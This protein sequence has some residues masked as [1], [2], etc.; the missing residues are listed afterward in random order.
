MV[1][2]HAL[3]TQ[4]CAEE[5]RNSLGLAAGIWDLSA[6]MR[7]TLSED[8]LGGES[9]K[10]RPVLAC[11]AQTACD[12]HA[13][14]FGG[15]DTLHNPVG[16]RV[17]GKLLLSKERLQMC[18]FMGREWVALDQ[19]EKA[20]VALSESQKCMK[21]AL[22]QSSTLSDQS[23]PERG[24]DPGAEREQILVLTH[25]LLLLRTQVL[26][27]LGQH[28]LALQM[29]ADCVALL[30]D[31]IQEHSMQLAAVM[32]AE[33]GAALA[34]LVQTTLQPSDVAGA[35][36]TLSNRPEHA[37]G[38]EMLKRAL[39][40]VSHGMACHKSVSQMQQTEKEGPALSV[41]TAVSNVT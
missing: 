10:F 27:R 41:D 37:A 32:C 29:A 21:I 1:H 12:L 7:A 25:D 13:L 9:N 23:E 14:S 18:M 8:Q 3:L 26:W 39:T 28:A 20:E 34:D 5:A 11:L 33:M 16:Q 31:K 6:P 4:A 15:Q 40:V 36:A 17:H 30:Q 24:V 38:V 19:L 22:E 2:V 35:A